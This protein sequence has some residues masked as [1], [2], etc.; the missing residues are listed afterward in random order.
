MYGIAGK[1]LFRVV[2]LAN[3]VWMKPRTTPAS[4]PQGE[5]FRSELR[6]ILD[7]SHALVKLA[8][9]VNWDRFDAAFGETYCAT[10]GRPGAST[11]L[12]V[13]LHYLKYTYDLSDES[14]IAGWVENPYWQYLSGMKY[15]CHE[16]PLD[17]S[18][19]TRWR[20]RI[21]E[22]GAEELLSETLDAG[23]RMKAVKSS[24]LKNINVDTTVQEKE[25]RFP[26]DARLYD[27]ARE[28]VVQAAAERGISLRQNYNRVNKRLLHQ[29]SRYAHARQF[30]RARRC[31]K[32]MRTHLGRVIRDLERKCPEVDEALRH[33]LE[34]A[35]R[36]HEQQRHDRNK[37]YSMHEPDVACIAKGKAHKRYEF[38]SKV[39][40][41]TTSKG[42][43]CVGAKAFTGNPYDGH[44][45]SPSLDQVERLLGRCPQRVFVDR[46]YRG[47]GYEGESEVHVDRVRRGRI[48][49]S[50]WKWMKRRS[51][52]EPT[53]GH[54]KKDRRLERNRLKGVEGDRVNVLMS[55]AAMNFSK[56]IRHAEASWRMF[57]FFSERPF[58]LQGRPETSSMYLLPQKSVA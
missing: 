53:L 37:V 41:A 30:K 45:L 26:T 10:T 39:S 6:Q 51:A 20:K 35:K 34:V 46:G 32:K 57:Q 52:I 58:V 8:H 55:A 15:F 21:G 16:P 38:G 27:R 9:E 5:L 12:M 24:Q 19:M 29:Q 25:I 14:V 49:K 4:D 7:G 50:V 43:W 42:G 54:L 33:T 28:H 17:S 1:G 22:A 3:T 18:S 23:L 2:K 56:L 44:T 31:T 48:K 47:H 36:I 11:R 40:V 13:S